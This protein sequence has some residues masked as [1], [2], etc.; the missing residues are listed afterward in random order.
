MWTSHRSHAGTGLSPQTLDSRRQIYVVLWTKNAV[1][2]IIG[3]GDLRE[4]CNICC[5]DQASVQRPRVNGLQPLG[6]SYTPQSAR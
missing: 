6:A 1:K 4:Y 2:L 5:L 3:G